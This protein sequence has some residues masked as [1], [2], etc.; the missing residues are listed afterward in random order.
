MKRVD[1]VR[2]SLGPQLE[3]FFLLLLAILGGGFLLGFLA[4]ALGAT[5]HGV[6]ALLGRMA[7]GL[8]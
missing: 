5:A 6:R 8:G 3:A 7:G 2:R 1:P 4:V